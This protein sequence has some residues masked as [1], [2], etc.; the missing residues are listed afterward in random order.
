MTAPDKKHT[1]GVFDEKWR[2]ARTWATATE[3]DYRQWYLTR[4]GYGT[5]E[6]LAAFL[7]GKR[8]ILEAGCGQA[9]D[10]K[11]FAELNSSAM[12]IAMDQSVNALEVA[13]ENLKEFPNCA[14]MRDDITSF[15][16]SEPF[17]FISCDQVMHHTPDPAA[18]LQH[19][20][21]HLAV[22]G[23]LNFFVCRK[24]GPARDLVDDLIMEWAKTATYEQLWAFAEEATRFG[25]ALHGL[26][27]TNVTFKGVVYPDLQRLVHN[28]LFRC[29]FNP[30]I[31]FE[32]S[33]SSNFDWFSGNPRFDAEEVR[34]MIM[35][36]PE[37]SFEVT[38]FYEDDP[39]IS[40]SLTR[41]R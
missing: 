39:S 36:L 12:I 23:T 3:A 18:T 5:L 34:G 15:A 30:N 11:M 40:V 35:T 41:L 17:D 29:W 38:R 2:C 16:L 8:R 37:G 14:I 1:F 26:G 6:G 25:K 20:F 13:M 21:G 4:Y 7:V 33:V 19:L 24:K 31:D 10:S 9:R 22:G 32:L 28:L 27:I